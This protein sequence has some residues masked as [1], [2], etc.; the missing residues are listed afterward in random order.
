MPGDYKIIFDKIEEVRVPFR[1]E[2]CQKIY[3]MS[4]EIRTVREYVDSFNRGR[5]V[6]YT[7]SH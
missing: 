6:T 7:R 3:D 2:D 5:I 1:N 4:E